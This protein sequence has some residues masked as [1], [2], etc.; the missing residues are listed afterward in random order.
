MK[1]IIC[2]DSTAASYAERDRPMTGWGQVLPEYVRPEVINLAFPGR[3]TKSFISEGRLV[4]AEKMLEPGDLLLIQFAHNDEHTL[5]WRHTDPWTS[6]LNN[7]RIFVETARTYDAIPV[8]LTPICLRTFQ[9]G[10]LLESHGDY[11]RAMKHLAGA[12]KVPFIDLYRSSL[13]AVDA[14]GDEGSRKWFMHLSPGES[15]A[16]PRGLQ[17]DAHTR[18]EGAEAMASFV[19]QGL[20]ALNLPLKEAL[21]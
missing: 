19:C 6:Y 14:L 17:D 13:E 1:I 3:S 11:P 18:R 2:G 4:E 5:V 10:R 20:L 15:E 7:L 12:E 8:L 9:E 21:Q 16:H